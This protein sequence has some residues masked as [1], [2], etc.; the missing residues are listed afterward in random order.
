MITNMHIKNIGIIDDIEINF[1]KGVNVL[2]G[3]TGAGKSLII[4]SLSVIC[5]GRFS[6]E[7]IRKGAEYSLVEICI[8]IPENI[9]SEDG[10]IIVSR[11]IFTNGKNLCKINGRFVT[12]SELKNYM[13][14]IID[15]HEQNDNQNI[16][17]VEKHIS[18]LDSF[19]GK[20]IEVLKEEYLKYYYEY[21]ELKRKL[22]ENFGDDK[23][24]ERTLDLLTYELNEIQN[25]DLKIG[26]EQELE[27]KMKQFQNSQKI[28]ESL[29][30]SDNLLSNCIISDMED[31][32]KNISK[33]ADI[34]EEYNKNLE[35]LQEA[36]YN[37]QDVMFNIS[38]LKENSDYD[39]ENFKFVEERLDLIYNLKRKYG[40]N[41]EE[42]LKYKEEVELKIN[43]IEN[44]ESYI[45]DLKVSLKNIKVK[46]LDVATKMNDLRNEYKTKLED[47]I[48][49]NLEEL[50]MKNAKFIIE[51]IVPEKIKFSENGISNL[52]FKISTNIGEDSKSLIKIASGGEISRIML[53]IKTVL[54]EY[55]NVNIVVLDEI[56]SG[57]SGKAARSV[58]E[59]IKKISKKSQV[60]CVT[61][62]PVVA[63]CADF[64]YYISKSVSCNTTKTSIKLLNENEVINEIARISS[65]EIT[66][67]SC[68][69]A[70]ELRK[71][72]CI[73]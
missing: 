2:T 31:V 65:G 6:K 55:D 25:A 71:I 34:N 35:V 8:Y 58:S 18:Y 39:K 14:D 42:I 20:K 15:I 61:H 46:M 48:N 9:N 12:V 44:L 37:I 52:E 51:N 5:G 66:E 73:A 24:R 54:S 69:H 47:E 53:A 43:K 26:E 36:Y 59:K 60:I 7:M 4:D 49:H 30:K 28:I 13:K 57:I 29:D 1:N 10:N 63:A 68:K 3:E 72:A 19:I 67:T 70:V 22:N 64:N 62:L 23:E 56:D 33:I 45:N 11:Q 17:D 40:N 38:S 21:K 41:I 16:M 27:S 32:I 50:E